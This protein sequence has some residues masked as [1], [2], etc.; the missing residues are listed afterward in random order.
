MF[1]SQVS[2]DLL[3]ALTLA[4]IKG[5][6]VV[7][8]DIDPNIFDVIIIDDRVIEAWSKSGLNRKLTYLECVA[9]SQKIR[10][11]YKVNPSID[12]YWADGLFEIIGEKPND[13]LKIINVALIGVFAFIA[14]KIVKK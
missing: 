8:N 10:K 12:K 1:L 3:I 13:L 14:Y 5:C 7:P 2:D 11:F 9:M 6:V 4:I